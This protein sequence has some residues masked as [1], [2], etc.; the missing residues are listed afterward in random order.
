MDVMMQYRADGKLPQ[1]APVRGYRLVTWAGRQDAPRW[2]DLIDQTFGPGHGAISASRFCARYA[3]SPGFV[4]DECYFFLGQDGAVV[5]S[6]FAWHRP[7]D[8]A[9]I[10]T[11]HWVAV[12]EAHRGQG[13]GRQLVLRVMHALISRGSGWIRLKT[14]SERLPAISLYWSLGFRPWA[15]TPEENRFWADCAGQMR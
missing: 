6:A 13:L 1:P 4:G 10:G 8:P 7:F 3:L 11:L 9:G 2:V 15:C 12:G 14:Q 5:G